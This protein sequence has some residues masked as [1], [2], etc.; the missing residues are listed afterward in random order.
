MKNKSNLLT[1]IKN[2]LKEVRFGNLSSR[3][4]VDTSDENKELAEDFNS[5]LESLQDRERML[6]ENQGFFLAKTEYLKNLFDMLNEGIIVVTEELKILSI[7]KIQAQWLRM[8]HK[9]LFGM[10]L[11]EVF[12]KYKIYDENGTQIGKNY[13]EFLKKEKQNCTLVFELK[14]IR[15]TFSVT[16]KKFLDKDKN[17][18]YFIVIK[19]ISSDAKLEKLK[20]TFIATLTHDLKVP[21]VAEEKILSLLLGKK[22]GEISPAQEE[23]LNNMLSNNSDMMSLVNTLLDVNKLDNGVFK[24]NK[25]LFSILDMVNDEVEKVRYLLAEAN[26]KIKIINSSERKEIFADEIQIGRVIMNLLTNAINFA[27]PNSEIKLEIF[28]KDENLCIAV[29]DKGSGISEENLPYVFERYFTKKYRK[30][31]TGLGLYLSKKIVRLHNGDIR[32]ESI[33]NKKTTFTVELPA[34]HAE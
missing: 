3:L 19:D 22:L 30:V 14:K 9:K 10:Y 16:T 33:P 15:M 8:E 31:G 5:M 28:D 32:A 34:C 26:L 13:L 20:E 4:S 1:R 12:E 29:S 27:P 24:L 21:I 7:N 2:I 23:A 17:I 18:N 6:T 25:S 11:P